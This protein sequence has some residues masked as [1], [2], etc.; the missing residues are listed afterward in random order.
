LKN[1]SEKRVQNHVIFA[2]GIVIGHKEVTH[3]VRY[4]LD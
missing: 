2:A 3:S 1:G 4:K